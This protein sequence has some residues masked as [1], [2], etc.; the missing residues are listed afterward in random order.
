MEQH[1]LLFHLAEDAFDVLN[2]ARREGMKRDQQLQQVVEAF[3]KTL[4]ES[5]AGIAL[6]KQAG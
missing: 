5:G 4:K 3:E 1:D 6:P 2:W